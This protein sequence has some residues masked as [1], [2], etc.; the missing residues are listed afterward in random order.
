MNTPLRRTRGDLIATG[1]IAGVSALLLGTAFFT[2]PA[3]DAHLVSAEEEQQD[4]GQLAVVPKSFSE[5]FTLTDTSGRDQPLVANGLVV[6]YNDHTLTATT[7]EGETVWTYERPNELCLVDQAWGKVVATYRDNAGCGDVV[8]IDAKTGTYA[9]TRSAIA[10]ERVVRLASNDRVGYASSER[11]EV[12]RSD[13][14][15]T[16]EYGYVEAKQEPD[17]QPHECTI[18]S[19][20]TRTELVAVTEVCDDGAF[21]R[22]QEAT[23]EDSRKP[24]VL[25]DV[26]ISPDAYLVA[27]S[28]DAAAVYD[29]TASEVRGYNK[30]GTSISSSSVPQMDSPEVGPDGIIKNLPVADLPHHMTYWE[31]NSLLLMEP[32]AL[33]VTGVFQGAL[34]TGFS[35][36]EKLLYASDSGIAVV[37]WDKNAVDTIIPVD[38]GGYTGPVHI[39]SAGAT[40]VEKR[41]DQVVV[42]RANT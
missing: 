13:L 22:L 37:D 17:M 18:T 28:Q 1:V 8:A 14:V 29:P 39:T 7:P 19:A 3:R 9:G 33:A 40:V 27:I 36:G 4:Y 20:L 30:E 34:G 10:P 6:T 23:P 5:G 15:R 38:R 26:E 41:G 42:L 25:A 21:L 31:N 16:V 35:A 12:W 2:A 32:A 11:A 24:E